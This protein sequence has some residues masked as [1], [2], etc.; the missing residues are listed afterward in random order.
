M[1]TTSTGAAGPRGGEAVRPIPRKGA[2]DPAARPPGIAGKRDATRGNGKGKDDA[3]R[4]P[5]GHPTVSP[6]RRR[7]PLVL[8]LLATL[9]VL[10][11][12]ATAGFVAMRQAPTY[13]ATAD[14]LYKG[15]DTSSTDVMARDL[16]TQQLVLVSP[17]ALAVIAPAVGRKPAELAA[18]TTAAVVLASSVVRLTVKDRS[19]DVAR[20]VA[21]SLVSQYTQFLQS[22]VA[23]R[24][25]Q[26]RQ[27]VDAQVASL[28]KR[29]DEIANRMGAIA[30]SGPFLPTTLQ[31][32]QQS[33]Q[34]QESVIRQQIAG[35]QAEELK[36]S[37]DN[38]TAGLGSAEVISPAA[39]LPA[40]VG[41]QPLRAAAAGA[42]VGLLLAFV[43]VV[44]VRRRRSTADPEAAV[45]QP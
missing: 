25:A 40:P 36:W 9:L 30:A 1:S 11:P 27:P 23:A 10:V 20:R 24:M 7:R 14:I 18:H 3:D 5:A 43:L 8:V 28:N 44:F 26:Q 34:V 17:R 2:A 39:V 4:R 29:L 45:A 42:L 22:R 15:V 6:R 31:A 35:L 19:R 37:T 41:P 32:E 33:L 13:A 38:P 16:Q 21:E 12:A